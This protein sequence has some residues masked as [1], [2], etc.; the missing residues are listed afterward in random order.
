M[1]LISGKIL[2]IIL[3][4]IFFLIFVGNLRD[5]EEGHQRIVNQTH[6]Q[7]NKE[8]KERTQD[9]TRFGNL[10]TSSGQGEIVLLNQSITGYK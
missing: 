10:P 5:K 9:L 8:K 1:I 2:K 7:L 4:D 6:E 3:I